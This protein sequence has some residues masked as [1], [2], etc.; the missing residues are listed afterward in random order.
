MFVYRMTMA[1]VSLGWC[2]S[3]AAQ[4]TPANAAAAYPTRSIRLV[5]PYPPGAAADLQARTMAQK[6]SESLGQ[7]V[8]V[9]NRGGANGIISME[10]VAKSPPD[11]YTITYALTEQYVI[12]PN[13]YPKI[14]Y[15]SVKDFAPISLMI[16]SPYIMFEHISVPAK[17]MEELI[18]LA[19]AQPGKLTFASAGN[20]ATGHMCLEMLKSI[21][22]VNI[23]HVPY[24][25]AAPALIDLL[26]GQAQLSF[27]AWSTAGQY[28]KNGQLR[29][30][31]V[32]TAKRAPVLP[33][34]PALAETLPGFD[35]AVWY[36]LAAPAGTPRPIINKLNS[37]FIKAL[38]IPE[39][40]RDFERSA[41]EPLGTTPEQFG[42]FIKTEMVKWNKLVKV[43]GAKVD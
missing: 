25:G 10:S 38:S 31:A 5:V 26:S 30:L 7:Q 16:R 27:L 22:G 35:V 29:A 33:D 36:G 4:S 20:G 12:N 15:D 9:D 14:P 17:T 3:V 34:I 18:A 11:G 41:M 43:S 1:A 2:A 21:T 24:K 39:L 19:K 13:L 8:I 42:D 6:V 28:V 23:T 32:T 37:E 40:K